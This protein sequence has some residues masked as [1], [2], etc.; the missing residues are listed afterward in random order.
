MMQAL[1]A[2]NMSLIYIFRSGKH[3]TSN[4]QELEFTENDLA[5]TAHTYNTNNHKAPVVIGH[6]ADDQPAY[7]WAESVT[8]NNGNLF[9]EVGRLS[10]ALVDA[11]RAGH[12]KYVS[13][14]FYAPNE[15]KNPA[16]GSWY[17]KHIGLLGSVP[18]AVKGLGRVSFSEQIHGH[19]IL[20]ASTEFSE[21]DILYSNRLQYKQHVAFTEP[22]GY[23]ADQDRLKIHQAA[24]KYQMIHG[25]G[26]EEALKAIS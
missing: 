24:I 14:S 21:A 13:A 16:K 22:L 23:T 8:S 1:Q 26:Y 18:P 5:L 11:V 9:A 25:V 4:G 12:Y 2:L 6:P 3:T 17:L 7:G 20:I 15:A 19:S 10:P